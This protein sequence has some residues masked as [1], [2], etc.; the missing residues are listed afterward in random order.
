MTSHLGGQNLGF[1]SEERTGMGS[2]EEKRQ[3]KENNGCFRPFL[4]FHNCLVPFFGLIIAKVLF[5]I[6]QKTEKS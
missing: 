2:Q 3:T 6:N 4:G 5:R 1:G